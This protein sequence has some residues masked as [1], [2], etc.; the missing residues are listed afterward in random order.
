MSSSRFRSRS[1][2]AALSSSS[3]SSSRF[4]RFSMNFRTQDIIASEA[5]GI[6]NIE[7]ILGARFFSLNRNGTRWELLLI[8]KKHEN[9][10]LGFSLLEP[11]CLKLSIKGFTDLK[12]NSQNSSP[13][14]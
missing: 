13:K 2:C 8:A 3:K 11:S 14:S 10:E 4:N 5:V 1:F 7:K 12:N 9:N 6:V